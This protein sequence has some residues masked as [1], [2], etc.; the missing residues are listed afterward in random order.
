MAPEVWC[1]RFS[2]S[3]DQYSLALA[4]AELRLDRWPFPTRDTN[5]MVAVMV[6]HLERS[7]E[8]AS[9]PA[10]EQ[11]VLLKAL[12]KDPAQRYTSCTEF[13]LELEAAVPSSGAV[14]AASTAW[15][16]S[17]PDVAVGPAKPKS[18]P[19]RSA[20]TPRPGSART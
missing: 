13:A 1:G 18:G 9:L 8:L 6:D 2:R 11:H 14:S 17:D 4:Y 7:P 5:D 3:S 10:D 15:R 19:M 16:R 20:S 12:A